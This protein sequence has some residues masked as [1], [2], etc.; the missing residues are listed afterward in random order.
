MGNLFNKDTSL[1]DRYTGYGLSLIE[2][3]SIY[4]VTLIKGQSQ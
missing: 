1:I 3:Y 2:R 4:S